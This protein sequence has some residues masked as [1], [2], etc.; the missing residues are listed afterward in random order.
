MGSEH[1]SLSRWVDPGL[2]FDGQ[3]ADQA[4]DLGIASLDD[5]SIITVPVTAL[6]DAE[7]AARSQC[8]ASVYTLRCAHHDAEE[9]RQRA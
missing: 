4:I 9:Q 3:E 7:T 2:V 6:S 1:V 8:A 5:N